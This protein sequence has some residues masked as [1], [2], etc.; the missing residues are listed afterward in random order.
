[1]TDDKEVL[2]YSTPSCPY[3]KMA[4]D[5]LAKKNVAYKEVDVAADA[6]AAKQMIEL[7]GQMGVPQIVIGKNVIVGYDPDEIER[8]L[9]TR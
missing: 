5:Y 2:V 1:M 7:S 8:A 4:K 9:S 3:C 6:N